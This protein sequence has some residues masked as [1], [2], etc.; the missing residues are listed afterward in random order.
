[1][2]FT[3]AHREQGLVTAPGNPLGLREPGGPREPGV[4]FAARNPGSGTRVWVDRRLRARRVRSRGRSTEALVDDHPSR[5]RAGPSPRGDADATV[6]VRA[7]AEARGLG[8]APALPG[9]LRPRRRRRPGRRARRSPPSLDRLG[10]RGFRRTGGRA[11]RIRPVAHRRRHA[12]RRLTEEGAD[13]RR[14]SA[15]A[16]RADCGKGRTMTTRIRR[17]LRSRLAA[18]LVATMLVSIALPVA[19]GRGAALHRGHRHRSLTASAFVANDHTPIAR[20]DRRLGPGDEHGLLGEDPRHRG[21]PRPAHPRTAASPGTRRPSQWVQ[22]QEDVSLSAHPYDRRCRQHRGRRRRRRRTVVLL[23]VRR[24]TKAG[25]YYLTVSLRAGERRV[26]STS[27]GRS[28]PTMTVMSMTAR[29]RRGSWVH[30][31]DPHGHRAERPASRR[32]ATPPRPVDLLAR[33]D[34]TQPRRRRRGRHRRQRALQRPAGCDR[35]L[36]H[37]RCRRRR[38]STSGTATATQSVVNGWSN[39]MTGPAD[40]DIALGAAETM[41]PTAVP[42]IKATGGNRTDHALTWGAATDNAG[43]GRLQ[44][45]SRA[46]GRHHTPTRPPSRPWP[47]ASTGTSWV[48]TSTAAG[49]DASCTRSAR[50]TPPPTWD[51]D[52]RP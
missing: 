8:Y 31:V 9:A 47:R 27:T 10:A 34:R 11:A 24:H 33:E 14:R 16:V 20:E 35:R 4:R 7:A 38:P 51:R 23:Q 29:R 13:R 2:M 25:T 39:F 15:D 6:A 49:R 30:N 52:P 22:E 36:P 44:R 43:G 45:L 17:S 28:Q 32:R 50:S 37:G 18:A 40:T 48:D 19:P 41:P 26:R 1:M 46:G 5:R 12:R 3:L 21:R 42:T